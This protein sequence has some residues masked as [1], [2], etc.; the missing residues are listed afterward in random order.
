MKD[1]LLTLPAGKLKLLEPAKL[2]Q[3]A[4]NPLPLANNSP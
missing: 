4:N 3:L 2:Q 1:L